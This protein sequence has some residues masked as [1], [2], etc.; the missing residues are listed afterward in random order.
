MSDRLY[1]DVEYLKGIIEFTKAGKMTREEM[2]RNWYGAVYAT[3]M[4]QGTL[5]KYLV[6]GGAA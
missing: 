3:F 2:Y 5:D 6:E 4:K 1:W